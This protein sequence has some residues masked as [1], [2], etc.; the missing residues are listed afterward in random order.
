M[1]RHFLQLWHHTTAEWHLERK[2]VLDH[3]ASDQKRLSNVEPDDAI[4]AVTV[5]PE[6]ELFLLGRL[7]VEECVNQEEAD[8]RFEYDVWQAKYHVIAKSGTEESLQ[9]I[10]LLH[11]A[12]DLRFV[13]KGND[14]LD[15]VDGRVNAQQLQTMREL[16]PESAR[17][18]EEKWSGSSLIDV[19][20]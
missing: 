12:Q 4:W 16:T 20:K 3:T 10:S 18:L 14:H 15:L 2:W 1:P 19:E 13:S 6:G 7:V 8:S 11:V 5:Y 9:E 17:M